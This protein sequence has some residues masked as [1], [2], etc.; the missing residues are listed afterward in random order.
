MHPPPHLW[1]PT[2]DPNPDAIRDP[3][4]PSYHMFGQSSLLSDL[5]A[6]PSSQETQPEPDY[7]KLLDSMPSHEQ[8]VLLMDEHGWP[9]PFKRPFILKAIFMYPTWRHEYLLHTYFESYARLVKM[10][11]RAESQLHQ[12]MLDRNSRAAQNE[13]FERQGM[14]FILTTDTSN[15]EV[16]KKRYSSNYQMKRISQLY[17]Q[18]VRV[19]GSADLWIQRRSGAVERS[20]QL[21]DEFLER[22]FRLRDDKEL[23]TE[24]EEAANKLARSEPQ[25]VDLVEV[26]KRANSA[27][28]VFNTLKTEEVDSMSMSQARLST[29]DPFLEKLVEAIKSKNIGASLEVTAT[30]E[31]PR[32]PIAVQAPPVHVQLS[33]AP[34]S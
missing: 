6:K 19:I 7:L 23:D 24:F 30:T 12:R 10:V 2:Y 15:V 20:R 5:R 16:F 18:N 1:T 31:A 33:S 17:Q 25:L 4:Q 34:K 28:D 29:T 21:A 27:F 9:N 26:E 32:I 13:E 3:T 11:H 14:T 8:Y 22:I